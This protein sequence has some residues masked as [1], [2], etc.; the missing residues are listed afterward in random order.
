M[1][2]SPVPPNLRSLLDAF[3]QEVLSDVHGH[4]IGTVAAIDPAARTVSVQINELRRLPNGTTQAYPLLTDVPLFTFGNNDAIVYVPHKVGDTCL[5]LFNDHDIDNWFVSGNTTTPNTSRS[6]SLSD[7]M[8]L[9][10][11][12]SKANPLTGLVRYDAVI[13]QEGSSFV[14]LGD[15]PVMSS[16]TAFVQVGTKVQ[17]RASDTNLADALNALCTALTTWVDTRGDTPNPATVAAINA[18][19][20]LIDS[21]LV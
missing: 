12:R 16:A 21:V 4:L 1:I 5:V 15:A 18:A 2:A 17:I 20:A 10:G 6:H 14:A 3:K 13:L 7:G 19:K 8:A 11:F 9:I